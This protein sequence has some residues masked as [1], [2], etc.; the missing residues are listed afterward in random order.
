MLPPVQG[1]KQKQPKDKQQL[2][3]YTVVT[4]EKLPEF[5]ADLGDVAMFTGAHMCERTAHTLGDEFKYLTREGTHM[6]A[7][8]SC[9]GDG[10]FGARAVSCFGGEGG[11][12]SL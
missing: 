7:G 9:H 2:F 12:Q 11:A 1:Q 3:V 8:C 4:A 5:K 10:L 6:A